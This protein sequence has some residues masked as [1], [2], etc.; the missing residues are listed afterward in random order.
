MIVVFS[1]CIF[2][3]RIDKKDPVKGNSRFFVI[4]FEDIVGLVGGN[5]KDIIVL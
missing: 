5:D 2:C 3:D 1:Q 4:L